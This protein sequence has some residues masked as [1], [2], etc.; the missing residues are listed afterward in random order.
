MADLLSFDELKNVCDFN[1][2]QS[3]VSK[4]AVE[5]GIPVISGG[6]K[7][8]FYH[9]QSNRPANT[10]TIAGSGAYAGFVSFH[11]NPI[12]AGD[13]FSIEVKNENKLNKKYLY[14]FLVNNQEKIYN[15]KTGAGIP[16]VHG[17]DIANF[18]IPI[19]SFE[20]QKEIVD[21][22]DRFSSLAESMEIGI[23]AEI[24]ANRQRYE[25]YRDEIF[26]SLKECA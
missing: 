22:L 25:Y 26:E 23:P 19:P 12:F 6:K 11:I 18:I 14:Y 1:R 13:C 3:I 7:P 10:I 15:K 4:D 20:R 17:K 5:G 2:G 21:I 16:H 8:A 9:N 24:K